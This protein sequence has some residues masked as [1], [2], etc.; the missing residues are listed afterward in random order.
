MNVLKQTLDTSTV[1]LVPSY[2]CKSAS[3][4]GCYEKADKDYSAKCMNSINIEKLIFF[5]KQYAAIIKIKWFGL[6]GGEITEFPEIASLSQRLSEEFPGV[7]L[8]F[9]TNGQ[10]HHKIKEIINRGNPI[11]NIEF[12][13]S[14][15]GYGN[16]C[17]KLRGKIGY[18]DEVLKSIRT[19]YDAGIKSI[20]INTRYFIEIEESIQKLSN[21]LSD[22]FAIKRSDFSLCN[23]T[24]KCDEKCGN[25][26]S[27]LRDFSVAFWESSLPDPVPIFHPKYKGYIKTTKVST[28]LPAIQP[29][30]FLYTCDNQY[31]TKIGSIYDE[32]PIDL[33]TRMLR[34]SELNPSQCSNC[35]SGKCLLRHFDHLKFN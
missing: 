15:D 8:I 11:S 30:G 19:V 23:V 26:F 10:N 13:F 20:H 32:A 14:I 22:E 21:Y 1:T 2:V 25:Y 4:P 9:V 3:C 31:G 34:F 33:I 12:E 7:K 27:K 16:V 28:C 5:L 18:F 6:I 35:Y 17:D 29:D 24:Q